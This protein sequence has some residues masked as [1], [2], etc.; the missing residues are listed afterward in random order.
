MDLSD[1]RTI[2]NIAPT[3]PGRQP[4]DS[5]CLMTTDDLL[6]HIADL[7]GKG[8]LHDAG[9][10]ARLV[11][12]D[13]ADAESNL[14]MGNALWQSGA[15]A[16]AVDVVARVVQVAP[17]FTAAWNTLLDWCVKL[18]RP[19]VIIDLLRE[20]TAARPEEARS[21]QLLAA[22]L[23]QFDDHT[24]SLQTIQRALE[25]DPLDV[26]SHELHARCLASLQS[27]ERAL[28]A[29]RPAVLGESRPLALQTRAAEI[30]AQ[31][32]QLESAIATMSK[33]LEEHPA[34]LDGWAKLAQ[35]HEA[36]GQTPQQMAA[37]EQV[38]RLAPGEVLGWTLRA[39]ARLGRGD[40][41]GAT[42]DYAAALR[43]EPAH[44]PA[45]E[46]LLELH[47][48][49]GDAKGAAEVLAS[50][51][52][53]LPSALRLAF[54]VRLAVSRGQSDSA[55]Q[56]FHD[57]C[58]APADD[59]HLLKMAANCLISDGH[60]DATCEILQQAA[61][62][63]GANHY[64]AA[65]WVSVC[66][67]NQQYQQAAAGLDR[68]AEN[69]EQWFLAAQCLL[70]ELG[71][72]Q[73]SS[74]LLRFVHR[75]DH[76]IGSD[77]RTWAAAG[78]AFSQIGDR[79]QCVA[80]LSDWQRRPNLRPHMLLPLALELWRSGQREQALPVSR[81]A[82]SLKADAARDTHAA[83]VVIQLLYADEVRSARDLLASIRRPPDAEPLAQ[84]VTVAGLTLEA[85][86]TPLELADS[87]PCQV[88]SGRLAQL[89]RDW[90]P[91]LKRDRLL[92]SVMRIAHATLAR[93]RGKPLAAAWHQ[94]R[95]S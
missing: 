43:I 24:Q 5:D 26:A 12:R 81:H 79:R 31:R 21:W 30:E 68:L 22:A 91:R 73:Q 19:G 6:N 2:D 72:A 29:C 69:S 44:A 75:H 45:V 63:R 70:L 76:L 82:L 18:H 64:A 36:M 62:R 89:Q 77:V 57:L 3:T 49:A 8:R 15:T 47:L 17:D 33:L 10:A 35:W 25:L 11:E 28:S 52:S 7:I 20:L 51:N 86:Q 27:Y 58:H 65:V 85:I 13:P 88:A 92:K 78:N 90:P 9:A 39:D 40:V 94:W 38:V 55:K 61:A 71:Q 66:A 67:E 42:A 34:H 4:A 54:E 87:D 32:G 41:N 84:L 60:R 53:A 59:D 14:A 16:E 37:I 50:A 56:Y 1:R 46:S 23:H 48:A 93:Y 83:L 74:L 80:W 95:A